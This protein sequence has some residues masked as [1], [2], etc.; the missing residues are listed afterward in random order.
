MLPHNLRF[1]ST[2]DQDSVVS[3]NSHEHHD[4]LRSLSR[5]RILLA[6]TTH[7]PRGHC[8]IVGRVTTERGVLPA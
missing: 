8:D 6:R 5:A 4:S 2:R 1:V 3:P 7:I